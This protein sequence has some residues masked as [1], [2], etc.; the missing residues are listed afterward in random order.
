MRQYNWEY[1]VSAQHELMP[2]VSISGGYFRRWY[3]NQTV[4]VDN[5]YNLSSY[6]GPFCVNAPADPNLPGG[7]AYAVCGLYDLKPALVSLPASSTITFS[8]NYGGEKNIYQ[9]FE[10]STVARF[11]QGA[12]FQAGVS[13]AKR[14]FD[15]CNLVDAGIKAAVLDAGTE[16]A[17]IYPDGSRSCHQE[18]GYRP[19][20]KLLGSYAL[21]D[22]AAGDAVDSHL[23]DAQRAHPAGP[24]PRAVGR[25]YDEV[26]EHH[27]GRYPI[28]RQQ[29]QPAGSACVQAVQD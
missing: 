8:S 10:V 16:V 17:E 21:A 6:D 9:G 20:L 19:D 29:S 13:A 14:I 4:T 23:G 15:Q 1:A 7:G 5:R 22:Q 24:R 26:R 27:R 12:F 25:R 3:G 11:R 28:R 2:R 18:F